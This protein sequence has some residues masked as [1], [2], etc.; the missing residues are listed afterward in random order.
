MDKRH[1]FNFKTDISRINIPAKLNNPFGL[2][3]PEI[4]RIAANEFQDFISS[5]SQGWK[6][7]FRIQ[8][9]KMFGILVVQKE[10]CTYSYLGTVS[11]KLQGNTICDKFVPSTFDDSI[12]DFFINRG[13]TELTEIGNQIKKAKKPSEI[14]LLIENRKQKS[15]ALQQRLF[16]NYQ[17]LNFSGIE[18]NVLQI[19][20]SSSH[21]NPPAAAGECAAPKLLQYAFKNRLKPIALAEFWWG[22][23]IKNQEREHKLFYPAC[24][25]KCRPILEYMLDDVEL[26]N[27]ASAVCE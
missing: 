24:K 16:E 14:S 20:E 12:D 9:G 15:F 10:D 18:K 17:F 1:I 27:Q 7:D 19:F 2:S 11:G 25:N 3:I 23:S 4:A 26:F 6:H 22:N 13:M 5:E 21:G 8:K